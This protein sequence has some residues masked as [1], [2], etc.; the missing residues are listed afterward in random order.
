MS[1]LCQ[2]NLPQSS[3]AAGFAK[4]FVAEWTGPSGLSRSPLPLP[5]QETLKPHWAE[6]GAQ[7]VIERE[8]DARFRDPAVTRT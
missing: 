8:I 7:L 5:R 3:T 6:K 2:E 1:T 4:A